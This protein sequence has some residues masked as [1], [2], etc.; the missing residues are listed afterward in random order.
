M[1]EFQ[2]DNYDYRL[3]FKIGTAIIFEP[4]WAENNKI[5]S[6][7]PLKYSEMVYFISDIPNVPGHCIV[8]TYDGRIVPMV[9]P[10][11]FREATEDET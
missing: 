7:H 4:E 2:Q 10:E 1:N 11:D 6:R 8:A 9:H 5:D 3:S